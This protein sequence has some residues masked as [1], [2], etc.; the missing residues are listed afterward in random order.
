MPNQD[1]N[2]TGN[3]FV[4]NL[5]FPGQ[6][7]D[8]ETG[9]FYNYFRDYDPSTGRY[10]ESDPRGLRGGSFSTYAYVNGNPLNRFDPFGLADKNYFDP[11]PG[12]HDQA[13]GTYANA[14]AWNP[15]EWYTV[16]GHGNPGNMED[17]SGPMPIF[18]MPWTLA[19]IIKNDPN[20]K[21]KP[22]LLG[23]CNTGNKWPDGF[24]G[25]NWIPFAQDLANRLGV[26]VTAPLDFV[27]FNIP[28][29]PIASPANVTPTNPFDVGPWRTYYPQLPSL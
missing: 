14:E 2:G 8:F 21:H 26:P 29:P 6:Y 25:K 3:Q 10:P 1:P 22:V 24:Q 17:R 5:R 12:S 4:F 23:S 19:D 15:S 16:A 13:N 7:Y 20:W 28:G 27:W 11:T 18:I 9:T